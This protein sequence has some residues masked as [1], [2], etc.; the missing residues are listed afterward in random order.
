MG[1]IRAIV[2]N[3]LMPKVVEFVKD[4]YV[5]VEELS[6]NPSVKEIFSASASSLH[7]TNFYEFYAGLQE[8]GIIN[9]R[10]Y[11]QIT[12]DNNEN[13]YIDMAT[14]VVLIDAVEEKIVYSMP[15]ENLEIME[16]Y[17]GKGLSEE[18]VEE[19][20][21][22]TLTY[23]MKVR[24]KEDETTRLKNR[25]NQLR[26]ILEAVNNATVFTPENVSSHTWQSVVDEL[27]NE[28]DEVMF[29]EP[30]QTSDKPFAIVEVDGGV[31]DITQE[32]DGFGVCLIDHDN[33][34]DNIAEALGSLSGF[35]FSPIEDRLQIASDKYDEFVD[36]IKEI[37]PDYDLEEIAYMLLPEYDDAGGERDDLDEDDDDL[38]ED[39]DDASDEGALTASQKGLTGD[40]ES[41]G[42]ELQDVKRSMIEISTAHVSQSTA[43]LL[44]N[45]GESDELFPLVVYNKAGYGWMI[46]VDE[47]ESYSGLPEDLA[48][49]IK[50]AQVNLID[51]IMMDSDAS[52]LEDLPTYDW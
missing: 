33:L 13:N 15:F 36:K 32:A 21:V 5:N 46:M 31:A 37:G 43:E 51:W 45:A 30:V 9:T 23:E 12:I 1:M 50:Y 4:N 24:G 41:A 3:E 18:G 35:K 16:N 39:E 49:V 42:S 11:C 29:S 7:V 34:Q 10:L 2:R 48:R 27:Q 44:D 40:T 22:A 6:E 38:D 8:F 17:E 26:K 47:R 52:V 14:K 20:L 25:V 19:L 28:A